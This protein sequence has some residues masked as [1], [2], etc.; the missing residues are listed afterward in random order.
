MKKYY[1]VILI[2]TNTINAQIKIGSGGGAM[3]PGSL[4]QINGNSVAENTPNSF[5]FNTGAVG[6]NTTKPGANLEIA[7]VGQTTSD[8]ASLSLNGPT[9][10][11]NRWIFNSNSN[12]S[13]L[14]WQT[15][16]NSIPVDGY[17]RL[18]INSSGNVG[19][20]GVDNPSANL[21]IKNPNATPLN[22]KTSL[23]LNGPSS[24]GRKWIFNSEGNG[25]FNIWDSSASLGQGNRLNIGTNGWVGIGT[26]SP[27]SELEVIGEISVSA[28][29]NPSDIRF[30]RNIN[31]LKNSLEK[32]SSLNGYSYFWK[33]EQYPEKK[34]KK[35]IDMGL[36]AQEVEKIYPEIVYTA[37]DEMN[38]KSIDY[39]KL[40]P[41]LIEA[42][43]ELKAEIEI[44]KARIN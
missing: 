37:N 22:N 21:E 28:I 15:N 36:I 27:N 9:L 39:A 3:V 5:I 42:I 40:V 20:G 8:Y 32:I 4:F 44:L 31:P 18:F 23:S 41:A 35:E 2:I 10:Q 29:R 17:N 1:L 24:S 33:S 14:L 30:K 13:F 19:I 6:I 25:S 43:K 11:G 34:F 7:S 12:G 16:P 26:T 38:S